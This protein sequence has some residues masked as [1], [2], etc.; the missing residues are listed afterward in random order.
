M[1]SARSL[2][3]PRSCL[4]FLYKCSTGVLQVFYKC[5]TSVLQVF[6]K[7][8]TSLLQVFY[9]CST[10][11][12]Q[13]FYKSSTGLLQVFYKSS[14]GLL[15]VFYRSSTGS[16]IPNLL[17]CACATCEADSRPG[18]AAFLAK[19]DEAAPRFESAPRSCMADSAPQR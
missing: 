4:Q 10:R 2:L 7:C 12:L 17:L 5:S 16:M 1:I 9:K 15:Q 18:A 8:S 6:Y 11:V 14:T 19:F 3:Y 13:M